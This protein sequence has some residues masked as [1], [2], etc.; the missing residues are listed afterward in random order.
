MAF[1]TAIQPSFPLN[2]LDIIRNAVRPLNRPSIPLHRLSRTS[3]LK[4]NSLSSH[5]LD[6]RIASHLLPVDGIKP[7]HRLVKAN[8][9]PPKNPVFPTTQGIEVSDY[10]FYLGTCLHIIHI[11][12]FFATRQINF[13]GWEHYG[14]SPNFEQ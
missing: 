6:G 10:V 14:N 11:F 7:K 12:R 4:V 5:L 8:Y 9:M 1:V 13:F 2:L 3:T